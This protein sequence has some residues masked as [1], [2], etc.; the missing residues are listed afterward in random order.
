MPC[1]QLFNSRARNDGVSDIMPDDPTGEEDEMHYLFP[2]LVSQLQN[3]AGII[4]DP[5]MQTKLKPRLHCV[6]VFFW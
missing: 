4:D 6:M 2:Y 5:A 1:I 3:G